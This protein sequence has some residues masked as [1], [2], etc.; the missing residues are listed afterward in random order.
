MYFR[1][2]RNCL[3]NN[4]LIPCGTI[5][6]KMFDSWEIDFFSI[7]E[8]FLSW[9]KMAA[10]SWSQQTI[11]EIFLLYDNKLFLFYAVEVLHTNS[12]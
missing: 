6:M 8:H 3:V 11:L 2:N 4:C 9:D 5:T 7:A 1:L 12:S 10:F